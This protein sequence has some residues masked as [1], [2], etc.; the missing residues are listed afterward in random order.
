[1]RLGKFEMVYDVFLKSKKQDFANIFDIV[2]RYLELSL[3]L[4]H[5]IASYWFGFQTTSEVLIAH[6]D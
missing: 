1:M 3:V 5:P 2:L 6:F 4:S